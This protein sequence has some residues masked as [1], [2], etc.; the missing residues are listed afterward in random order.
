MDW[1]IKY[2]LNPEIVIIPNKTRDILFR[3]DSFFHSP[4]K[5]CPIS[6]FDAIFLLLFD[7]NRTMDEV[8]RDLLLIYGKGHKSFDVERA[9]EKL[10]SWMKI[11]DLLI[12]SETLAREER[13]K[14]GDRVDPLSLL[15]DEDVF[16]MQD[17]NLRLDAPLSLNFNVTTSCRFG[18]E[19]CYHPLEEIT[20]LIP[21]S[22]L[23]E[24]LLQFKENGCQS[25]MLT[26]GDPMLRPDI[27]EIMEYLHEI[28]LFYSISTKSILSEERIDSLI[29]RAGLDRIQIS[30]DSNRAEIVEKTIHATPGYFN[31]CVKMIKYMLEQGI[32]VRLKSVLTSFNADFVEEYFDF[33]ASLGIKHVQLVGYGRSGTRHRDILFPSANQMKKAS[34]IVDN[35]RSKYTDMTIVG[36]GYAVQTASPV[37]NL[38]NYFERR[39]V[40]NAGRFAVTML[41]DGEVTVCEQLPYDKKYIIGD[42]SKE[43]LMQWWNGDKVKDWLSPPKREEF[44]P[45]IPCYDCPED[46][47]DVCH[48]KYS[49]CLRYCRE[50]FGFTQMPDIRCPGAEFE[51][52]RIG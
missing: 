25:V 11:D 31:S 20:P 13:I 49:R 41:P 23:K 24:I 39:S 46:N 18:C 9:V 6:P 43:D 7:G 14:Y 28:G 8:E 4:D 44:A 12:D 35:A 17:G 21:L 40:C 19:Y 15:I 29:S 30:L 27:D 38:R 48:R 34:I 47:Y 22:R 51:D 2:I 3:M 1:R 52:F 45:G 36:G 26:G 32:D 37:K 42:L 16:D 33:A 5:I 10:R 50:Y